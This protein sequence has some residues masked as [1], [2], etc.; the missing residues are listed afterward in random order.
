MSSIPYLPTQ[1]ERE[2]REGE[3]AN[4]AAVQRLC[5][6]LDSYTR[7]ECAVVA[8]I[9]QRC[10]RKPQQPKLP[11]TEQKT[12]AMFNKR[13]L[14]QQKLK[15]LVKD[16]LCGDFNFQPRGAQAVE[17]CIDIHG[18]PELLCEGTGSNAKDDAA[19]KALDKLNPSWR[20]SLE[21]PRDERRAQA[22]VGDAALDLLLVLMASELGLDARRVDA[23]RQSLLRNS[24]LGG[25]VAGAARATETEAAVGQAVLLSRETLVSTLR[26]AVIAAGADELLHNLD[27][28]VAL[29]GR[30]CNRS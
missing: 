28:A 20:A 11:S 15:E 23:L 7:C 10:L 16:Q 5:T 13:G 6:L 1:R 26:D 2:A 9:N 29:E 18:M 12:S 27:A 14:P 3:C 21:R 24:A 30:S 19:K 4:S 22:L 25:G 17:L 8:L